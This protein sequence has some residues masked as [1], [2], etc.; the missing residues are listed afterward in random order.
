LKI[1]PAIILLLWTV[2]YG[3]CLA[4][5]TG[6]L[7]YAVAEVGHCA[8][9]CC[10][11][12]DETPPPSEDGDSCPVCDFVNSGGAPAGERLIVDAPVLFPVLM[13]E[14]IFAAVILSGETVEGTPEAL[15]T[16]PPARL[17]MCE[18]MARTATPV[19]GPD[20]VA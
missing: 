19:R 5:Q 13:P 12:E 18:W 3:R 1:L 4:E 7:H 16:G 9:E 20:V 10:Q 8:G 6:L 14:V 17:R 2:C 11:G 15:N